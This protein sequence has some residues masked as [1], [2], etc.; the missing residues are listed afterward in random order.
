MDALGR[1]RTMAA[2]G[3]G[4]SIADGATAV[5]NML[6][7]LPVVPEGVA[8]PLA[9]RIEETMRELSGFLQPPGTPP[10]AASIAAM[11]GAITRADELLTEGQRAGSGIDLSQIR[12]LSVARESVDIHIETAALQSRLAESLNNLPASD[13]GREERTRQLAEAVRLFSELTGLYRSANTNPARQF[14]MQNVFLAYI[15]KFSSYYPIG[16]DVE[17]AIRVALICMDTQLLNIE[18]AL[19]ADRTASSSARIRA[20]ETILRRNTESEAGVRAIAEIWGISEEDLNGYFN[21]VEANVGVSYSA[22]LIRVRAVLERLRS[23]P[24]PAVTAEAVDAVTAELNTATDDLNG[25]GRET[26]EE[27]AAIIRLLNLFLLAQDST[28][29]AVGNQRAL[30][31]AF[32]RAA[33]AIFDRVQRH[34]GGAGA[35]SGLPVFRKI[36]DETRELV[37]YFV[38]YLAQ[39]LVALNDDPTTVD[40]VAENLNRFEELLGNLDRKAPIDLRA[41]A[42]GALDVPIANLRE[43]IAEIRAERGGGG[44]PR[45]AFTDADIQGIIA[46][47]NAATDRLVRIVPDPGHLIAEEDAIIAILQL[48]PRAQA[49]IAATPAGSSAALGQLVDRAKQTLLERARNSVAGAAAGAAG[50]GLLPSATIEDLIAYLTRYLESEL[51]ILDRVAYAN[52][53]EEAIVQFRTLLRELEGNSFID[54]RGTGGPDVFRVQLEAIDARIAELRGGAAPP[55]YTSFCVSGTRLPDE[56]GVFCVSGAITSIAQQQPGGGLNLGDNSIYCVSGSILPNDPAVI[57]GIFCLSGNLVRRQEN[58]AAGGWRGWAAGVGRGVGQGVAWVGRDLLGRV[59][60]LRRPAR[61][62]DLPGPGFT[63]IPTMQ[64][65]GVVSWAAPAGILASA[66]CDGAMLTTGECQFS[67]IQRDISGLEAHMAS[68]VAS[69]ALN[70]TQLKYNELYQ[71]WLDASGAEEKQSLADTIAARFPSKTVLIDR[72][73][74]VVRNPYSAAGDRAGVSGERGFLDPSGTGPNFQLLQAYLQPAEDFRELVVGNRVLEMMILESLWHCGQSVGPDA[75]PRCFPAKVIEELREFRGLQDQKLQHELAR[76]IL[77]KSRVKRV[78]DYGEKLLKMLKKEDPTAGLAID[79]SAAVV[80]G[81][82]GGGGVSGEMPIFCV[83]GEILGDAATG[84]FC[85]SGALISVSGDRGM[86]PADGTVGVFCVSGGELLG[87]IVPGVPKC[88]RGRGVPR[89]PVAPVT[90]LHPEPRRRPAPGLGAGRGALLPL[91]G[92]LGFHPV[93]PR[94]RI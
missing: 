20:L 73:P 83:S 78:F 5:A 68:W 43:R 46:Q 82:G 92:G 17:K 91:T 55:T 9:V 61:T 34:T 63:R 84:I 1:G 42:T 80:P 85:V 52:A 59:D 30:A 62:A 32:L 67:R 74:F 76:K 37:H 50:V 64:P 53:A 48:F 90:V 94:P 87:P 45:T 77:D 6:A 39:Q 72:M 79:P 51:E 21:S 86:L 19:A 58:A 14:A 36:G 33:R 23:L 57:T 40:D 3:V 35:A 27:N 89:A 31:T 81:G 25:T 65:P 88:I 49:I 10:A 18:V 13:A 29:P 60:S 44:G 38:G 15:Q 56:G 54:L 7:A 66:S 69:R 47:L 11:R 16:G 26:S 41:A 2:A 24:P 71:Q 12:R 22:L 28:V 70:S 8:S 4:T 75:D 93:V